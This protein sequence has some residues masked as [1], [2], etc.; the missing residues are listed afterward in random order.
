MNKWVGTLFVGYLVFAFQPVTPAC[1][2]KDTSRKTA[3]L[4]RGGAVQR[5]ANSGF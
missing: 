2:R 5:R 4:D 3:I 1:Q